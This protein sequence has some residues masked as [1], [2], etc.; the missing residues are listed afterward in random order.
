[1]LPTSTKSCEVMMHNTVG[2]NESC[3]TSWSVTLKVLLAAIFGWGS[4]IVL[5][6]LLVRR[7][8]NQDSPRVPGDE[9]LESKDLEE[10]LEPQHPLGTRW[11]FLLLRDP[12]WEGIGTLLSVLTFVVATI[13]TFFVARWTMSQDQAHLFIH[14][15]DWS[16]SCESQ[17]QCEWQVTIVIDNDGPPTANDLL[18]A[19]RIAVSP[20]ITL[21]RLVVLREG[22]AVELL[23]TSKSGTITWG[24]FLE[25]ALQ[26]EMKFRDYEGSIER[27][28]VG[29]QLVIRADFNADPS[30]SQQ[31]VRAVQSGDF[32]AFDS[33]RQGWTIGLLRAFFIHDV[34]LSGSK[35]VATKSYRW[36]PPRFR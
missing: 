22:G 14:Q 4:V 2:R 32:W 28:L 1:M 29:E 3:R 11:P 8:P 26:T 23:G 15:P 34:N 12:A 7:K 30:F 20:H 31:F 33:A 24:H 18:V 6:Y 10:Q 5:L 9:Q 17:D 27:L 13:L 36:E 19:P 25:G 21:T 16:M 35:V